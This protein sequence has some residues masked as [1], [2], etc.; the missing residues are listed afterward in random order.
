MSSVTQVDLPLGGSALL[1]VSLL[2]RA[3]GGLWDE[4]HNPDRDPTLEPVQLLEG[5]EYRYAFLLTNPPPGAVITTDRPEL[6]EPDTA[7]GLTGRLRPRLHTGALPVR[8]FLN[9]QPIGEVAFEVRSR[10]LD[11]LSH[12]RWMLRDI[13]ENMAELVMERFAPT[14]QRFAPDQARDSATLYQ[15]FAF[16]RSLIQSDAFDASIHQILARPHRAWVVAEESRPPGRGM[17]AG[18]AAIRQLS[19]PGRRQRWE[20][21]ALP[22]IPGAVQTGRTVPTLDTPE[23]QFVRF[24]LHHFRD[25]LADT[26]QA[27]AGEAEPSGPVSRGQR[28]V[29]EA[30]GYLDS[31]LASDLFREVGVLTQLPAGSQVLQKR[32]G[33]RD[34][35]RA[36]LQSEAA[37]MLAWEGGEDVYSAGQRNVATLYE[38][39]VFLQLAA[40][41]AEG[42]QSG[43][44]RAALF[45][46]RP[47]GLGLRLRRGEQRVLS[48]T[49]IR[50]GRRLQLE[51][52]FNRSF[53][54]GAAGGSWTRP[55]RPD[56]S[57]RIRPEPPL[58]AGRDEIW[59]HFDAKYR[60]DGV[61]ELFGPLDEAEALPAKRE[62]LLKMHAY[63]DAIH[64]SAGAYVIYPGTGGEERQRYHEILPGLGAFAL[65]PSAGGE[66]E[67]LAAL[68]AFLDDVLTHVASQAS[69]HE[70]ERYWQ[71]VS[72]APGARAGR[73]VAAVPFLTRP[74]ADTKVLLGYVKSQAHLDWVTASCLYNLRA[75]GR[76]GTIPPGADEL[77]AEILLL[78]GPP[79][80]APQ[81]W[82]VA[83]GPALL[84]RTELLERGYPAPG[85]EFYHGLLLA[86]IPRE[87]W[88]AAVTAAK[89]E[90]L[91]RARLPAGP[92]G[93]P[94]AVTWLDLVR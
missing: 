44:D 31:I 8:L 78:Y 6:F 17:P 36:F 32:A 81:F 60:V 9:A 71:A 67:G 5:A 83:G 7:D 56:C 74:P 85:G 2:P 61:T 16:L 1:R 12:Y 40:V 43:L 66:A 50:Q 89:V 77:A 57:L 88:P 37:A 76:H 72:W 51:F 64:R 65:R 59:I 90:A 82:R 53:G 84:T 80:A 69:Q 26:G 48:G 73:P 62:D 47:D 33:Y 41:V 27:L 30:L 24:V 68:A 38:F 70:R 14:E 19:R 52:W 49:A 79:L 15:R 58:P 92:V 21:G 3:Q 28:E 20:G 54:V 25:L 10:K 46:A 4:R 93:A 94:V 35:F 86:P 18:T 42:C 87:Q 23:N 45:E 39:W 91:G 29:A 13:A 63:R 34:L 22:T 75:D 11:Y 55:M